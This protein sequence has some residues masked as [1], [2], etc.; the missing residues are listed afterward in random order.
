MAEE[1]GPAFDALCL[2]V[3]KAIGKTLSQMT[4]YSAR[5]PAVQAMIA[6]TAAL[7]ARIVD[8][9]PERE[10]VYSIDRDKL[11]ANGRI[12]GQ[13]GAVPNAVPQ[14]FA[15]FHLNSLSFR[16]GVTTEGL[17]AL[18]E[19]AGLR[20]EA[21]KGV[22]CE[23]FLASKG[24]TGIQANEAVY[25]KIQKDEEI[26]AGG[27]VPGGGGAGAGQALADQ[28]KGKSLDETLQALVRCAVTDPKDQQI[29][30]DAVLK[31]VREDM[32]KE[33]RE[34]TRELT[35]QKRAVENEAVRTTA[36]VE[37]M[38][39][40]VVTIDDHGNVLMMNPEAEAL[41]GTRLAA[42]AGKPLSETAKDEHMVSM[43]KELQ[44]S[45]DR[46][47]DKTVQVGGSEDVRRTLRNSTAVIQNE[48]GKPVG[49]VATFSDKAKQRELEHMEREFVA[50]VTHELRAPLTAI[51]AAL[52][53]IDGIAAGRM[54]ADTRS[55]FDN[56]L[57]NTDRLEGLIN[58]ILDFSKIEAGQMTVHVKPCDAEAIAR[59]ATESLQ[60]WARK[61]GVRMEFF[62]PT[63]G[64]RVEADHQRTVQVLVNLLSNAIKFTPAGGK[65]E[66]SVRP[67]GEKHPGAI[68]L[69]VRDTGPGI[70]KEKQDAVFEKFVQIAAGERHVGGTGLGL[71]IA[72]AL[73]HLQK[74]TMWVSSAPGAGAQFCFTLPLSTA[75]PVENRAA[76]QKS[77][78]P[79]PFWKRLLGLK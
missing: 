62:A 35:F 39:Q 21:A 24:V 52:E 79:L 44:V 70:P 47:V 49:M 7:L 14:L 78:G 10:I 75:A 65:V 25:A 22:S 34:A 9:T 15:R 12:I 3:L 36:V 37:S 72:K 68:L 32:E 48:A 27:A 66:V 33:V 59:E 31:R 56:A 74:G 5:H 28:L 77:E 19:L 73:V 11:L 69:A 53:I 18:C 38:A 23:Q 51:R 57:R 17:S 42:A 64:L 45:G 20:P 71:A 60:P 50:H 8:A 6:E 43:A 46:D 29:L 41:F 67:G 40:G 2:D 26:V 58:S 16:E 55:V 1:Q 13:A 61:K 76:P 30:L 54:S 63:A 4:L